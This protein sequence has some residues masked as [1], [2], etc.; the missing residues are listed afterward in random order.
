MT[1]PPEEI[2]L[3]TKAIADTPNEP[4][5]VDIGFNQGFLSV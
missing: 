2:Y 5:Y 3:M 4:E 1:E